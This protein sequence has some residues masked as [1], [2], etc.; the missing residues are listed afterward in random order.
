LRKF[1]KSQYGGVRNY[2]FGYNEGVDIV[3]HLEDDFK[4]VL[5][6]LP[7][8]WMP[9]YCLLWLAEWNLL[10]RGI[11]YAPFPTVAWLPDWDYNIPYTRMYAESVDLII[12]HGEPDSKAVRAFT[13]LD[14]AVAF[15]AVGVMQEYFADTPKIIKDRKYDILYTTWIDDAIQPGRSEWICRLCSLSDRYTVHID[16]NLKY[17]EYIALCD[18]NLHI[19]IADMD[20]SSSRCRCRGAGC[21]CS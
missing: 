7:Q 13:G 3:I 2:N 15:H 16:K 6:R 21:Y 4:T 9:D 11:E 18:S 14:N 20:N 19:L 5:E 1:Y 8:G 10:P 12:S 17:P